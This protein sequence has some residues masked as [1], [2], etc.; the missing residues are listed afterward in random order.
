MSHSNPADR[1]E[2][3]RQYRIDNAERR[4]EYQ[5]EYYRKNREQILE[6]SKKVGA[7][8]KESGYY[9]EWREKNREHRREW[10]VGYKAKN[11]EALKA[12]RD[13]WY[14]ANRQ[15]ILERRRIA[16]TNDPISDR[17]GKLHRRSAGVETCSPVTRAEL[18]LIPDFCQICEVDAE[19]LDHIVPVSRGGCSALHNLQWLCAWCNRSKKAK[20]MH[21]YLSEDEYADWAERTHS[22]GC[23]HAGGDSK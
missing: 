6:Y 3:M 7:E 9:V 11:A 13:E 22:L 15:E 10:Y 19:E 8:R 23:H 14:E 21:E 4:K 2:Y 18:D 20:L 1:A 16:R 12:Y 17:L 5:R